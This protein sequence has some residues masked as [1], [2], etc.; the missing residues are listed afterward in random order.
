MTSG[1]AATVTAL[2]R[3]SLRLVLALAIVASL[4]RAAEPAAPDTAAPLRRA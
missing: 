2:H 3:H 1:I 4:A